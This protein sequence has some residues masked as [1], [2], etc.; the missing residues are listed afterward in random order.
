M[1]KTHSYWD[2]EAQKKLTKWLVHVQY[3]VRV[4]HLNMFHW[5]MK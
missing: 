4:F 1:I 3:H 5:Y 2:F